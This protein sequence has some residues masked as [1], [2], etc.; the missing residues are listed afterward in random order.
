MPR[1]L[2]GVQHKGD[3]ALPGDPADGGPVLDRAGHVGPVGHEDEPGV[4][5]DEG[6]DGLRVQQPRFVGHDPIEADPL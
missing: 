6:A 5:A 1:R 2:G 3:A 4:G